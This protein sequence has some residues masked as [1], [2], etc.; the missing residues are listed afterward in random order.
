MDKMRCPHHWMLETAGRGPQVNGT[1]L[2]CGVTKDDFRAHWDEYGP[3]SQDQYNG[4]F[5]RDSIQFNPQRK[6]L[7]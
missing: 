7:R 6:N 4:G 5:G 3:L 2:M 1:C